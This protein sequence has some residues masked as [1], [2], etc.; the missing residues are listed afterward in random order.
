MVVL[1]WVELLR[2]FAVKLGQLSRLHLIHAGNQHINRSVQELV[3]DVHLFALQGAVRRACPQVGFHLVN[4][5]FVDFLL[6]HSQAIT[7]ESSGLLMI[8]IKTRMAAVAAL[9]VVEGVA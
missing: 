8:G 6:D 2:Q 5:G 1:V 9:P 7:L 3:D 4:R